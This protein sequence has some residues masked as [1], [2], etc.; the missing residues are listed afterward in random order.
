MTR[1][2][3]APLAV[4]ARRIAARPGSVLLTGLGIALAS[5]ALTTL[6]VGQVIVEDR[7]VSDAI[8][9]IPADE[10]MVSVSWVG[11]GTRDWTR[12]DREARSEL[13]ALG[14]GD[15]LRAVGFRSTRFGTDI[16]RL[17]A[18]DDDAKALLELRSGRLPSTCGPGRCELVALDAP[19]SPLA[20]PGLAVTGSVTAARGA[21]LAA[22]VG[23][24]TT[25]E[26]VFVGVGVEE[27]ARRPEVSGLFR[28]LTWAVPLDLDALDSPK[29]AEL[30]TRMAELDTRLR[31]VDPALAAR[32]PIQDLE[33]ARDRA[34]NASRRQLLVG[35]QCVVVFLAFA[36]LAASRIRR[37]AGETRFRLR[38]LC[39][40]RWQIALETA[41]YAV[42]VALPA[43]LV[44]GAA[45]LVAGAVVADEAGRPA[46]DAL[47]RALSS[48][49]SGWALALLALGA[50]VVLIATTRAATL[51]SRGRGITPLDV[52]IAA[53]LAAIAAAFLFGET[54]AESL[55]R[56]GGIGVSLV[57]L[58]VLVALAGALLVARAFPALLR[59]GERPAAAAGVSLRLALLSLVRSPGVAAVAV[60]C[61]T[62]TVGMAV[63]A[64]TYRATLAANQRDAAAHAVPLEYVVERDPT[65]GLRTGRTADLAPSYGAGALGVIRRDGDAPT[66]NRSTELTVLGLPPDAFE[67]MRWRRDYADES[68]EALGRS[69]A[70]DGSSLRGVELPAEGR[71]LVLPR[72]VRGDPIRISAEVRRPDGGFS[73][74]DLK[75]NGAVAR[76]PLSPAVRGGTLVGLTLAFPPIAEFT[77]AHRAT[78]SRAAPDVFLRGTLTL[79]RPR[80]GTPAGPR[81]LAVDYGDWVSSEGRGT[82]GSPGR[83]RIRYFLSQERT[84]RIR[85]RQSTDDEPIPVIASTS[86]VAGAGS[87]RVLPIR[88]GRAAVDARIVGTADRFPTLSGD[89]IVADKEA[90]ATAANA[91]AP[92]TAVADE[93]WLSAAPRAEA[94]FPVRVTSRAEL[95]RSLRADPVSRAAA[96]A[97]LAAALLAGFLALAGLVLALAVDARD[98]A[99]DLFDLESLGFDPTRLARHLWLRSAVILAAG[100]IG[101]LVTGGLASL[102]VTDLVAVTANVTPAEPPLVPVLPWPLLVAGAIVF[103]ALALGIVV[104]LAHRSFRAAAPARPEAA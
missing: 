39:A 54:D 49:G 52:A 91:A 65:R 64:L 55:A 43:V 96:I 59:L 20:A 44:G 25:A 7:A 34:T 50:V 79:G 102:L 29:A 86:I 90:L 93:A 101:G 84:F 75:G 53:V 1:R 85:P 10:R 73:V 36:V 27:L 57:L 47:R 67:R 22:L 78:G 69:I 17:A 40:L 38:R 60:A 58:P 99:G 97:L 71:E 19:Q 63:F 33:A 14:V 11:L 15:P 32:A 82:G 23:S 87:A 70:Y 94:P 72:T 24:T 66:L 61:L 3:V 74:L 76:A 13:R 77:T 2:V 12:L 42:L 41:G 68:P 92:G 89:F 28:T 37:N 83:A 9:R 5:A 81:A 62:V 30:P 46:G 103:G 18:V 21:P 16:V 80:V 4:A 88:V 51:E 35:A 100:L 6:L 48:A 98:D 45:G 56:E 8:G 104:V 95:E 31:Q 26:R